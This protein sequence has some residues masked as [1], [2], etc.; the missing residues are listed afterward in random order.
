MRS[1]DPN[2]RKKVPGLDGELCS[3]DL[4]FCLG[5]VR[6]LFCIMLAAIMLLLC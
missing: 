3:E 5:L 2:W 1:D 6:I 4:M